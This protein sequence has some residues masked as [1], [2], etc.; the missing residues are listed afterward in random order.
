MSV[1]PVSEKAIEILFNR[2]VLQ[3]FDLGSVQLFA[4]TSV[5]EFE[6]GYD[7]RVV[8]PRALR[9]IYLQFKAPTYSDANARYTVKITPHQHAILKAMYPARSAYYVA[10]MFR[11][12]VEFG[13]AQS[14]LTGAAANF[15]KHFVCIDIA[16]LPVEVDFLNYEHPE[17]HLESPEVKFKTPVDGK[18]RV[19]HRAV[20]AQAWC[21]GST[22]LRLFKEGEVGAQVVPGAVPVRSAEAVTGEDKSARHG[23]LAVLSGGDF[24]VLLRVQA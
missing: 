10:P 4:P 2:C 17:N 18:V 24:G 14:T 15:L 21:R 7:G 8:G 23:A 13:E 5:E 19:A 16:S 11:T 9:E 12:L 22:L 20:P 3:S 1:R 6:R